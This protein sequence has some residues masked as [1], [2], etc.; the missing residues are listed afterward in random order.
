MEDDVVIY[1]KHDKSFE[2]TMI[3]QKGDL[4]STTGRKDTWLDDSTS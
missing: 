4:D 1:R 2:Q 3:S